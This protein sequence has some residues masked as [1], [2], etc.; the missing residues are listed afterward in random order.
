MKKVLILLCLLFVVSMLAGAYVVSYKPPLYLKSVEVEE[1]P[2]FHALIF[3]Y[4]TELC[5][6]MQLERLM[7][8][9]EELGLRASLFPLP[10]DFGLRRNVLFDYSQSA[11]EVQLHARP[12]PWGITDAFAAYSDATP[13]QYR[14]L[15]ENQI[16]NAYYRNLFPEIAIFEFN[17]FY[18]EGLSLHSTANRLPWTDDTNYRIIGA[19]AARAG[20][21]WVSVTSRAF[22]IGPDPT[23]TDPNLFNAYDPYVTSRQPS[24]WIRIP[25][26]W[27]ST[28]SILVIPTSWR[29]A[30]HTESEDPEEIRD[31][32][33]RMRK[34]IDRHWKV[35]REKGLPLVLLMHPVYRV[36]VDA[37]D[38]LFFNFRRDLL[39][40]AKRLDV[41]VMTFSEYADHLA[42]M[43]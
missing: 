23:H 31:M 13:Y 25:T 28:R 18:P 37:Q 8:Q 1:A 29:D 10:E 12:M 38:E 30:Y 9:D 24:R 40:K 33:A 5:S 41:P 34:D 22:S 19:A 27:G 32:Y 20:F 4:D 43:Q 15:N 17:G 21:R 6:P 11:G 16:L 14:Y 7:Q 39:E 3:R 42:A 26:G 35:A 2:P 36:G